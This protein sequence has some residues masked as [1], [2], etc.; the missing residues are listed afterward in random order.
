MKL[1]DIK[2]R[3][4]LSEYLMI[5][6]NQLCWI[7]YGKKTDN[8]YTCFTIPK[9]NGDSRTIKAPCKQLKAIIKSSCSRSERN[10]KQLETT[11]KKI[12]QITQ[13]RQM[14]GGE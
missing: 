12:P 7:L 10:L 11:K 6:Y 3:Y 5:P 8:L 2:N 13:M 1:N 14:V 9:R 4:Q